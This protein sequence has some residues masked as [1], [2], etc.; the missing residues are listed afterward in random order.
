MIKKL[1]SI[2]LCVVLLVSVLPQVGFAAGTVTILSNRTSTETSF[3]KAPAGQY[4]Q[5]NYGVQLNGESADA[6][7]FN[8][9]V[10]PEG[11]GVSV[12][13]GG[14][15]IVSGNTSLKSFNLTATLKT[16]STATATVNIPIESSVLYD[17]D[18]NIYGSLTATEDSDGNKYLAAN[19]EASDKWTQIKPGSFGGVGYGTET[20]KFKFRLSSVTTKY[21]FVD[22]WGTYLYA[23]AS[24]SDPSKFLL[25]LKSGSHDKYI[26]SGD[27]LLSLNQWHEVKFEFDFGSG[28][29]N[30]YVDDRLDANA[31]NVTMPEATKT[32]GTLRMKFN[33]DDVVAYSGFDYTPELNISENSK[34]LLVPTVNNR[35][36]SVKF[37]ATSDDTS[38][39]ITWSLAENY[40]GVT[41]N[42]QT[43]LVTVGN[44]ASSGDITVKASQGTQEKTATLSLTKFYEDF[45]SFSSGDTPSSPWI[46]GSFI[47]D[48][49]NTYLSSTKDI[50][51]RFFFPQVTSGNNLVLEADVG[52]LS[53]TITL[54]A[55]NSWTTLATPTSFEIFNRSQWNKVK[56]VLDYKNST[57]SVFVNGKAVSYQK[58]MSNMADIKAFG[59]ESANV[60]NVTVYNVSN[61]A[62][63]AL[64]VELPDVVAGD[65]TNLS[66]KYFDE[67]G[68][69]ENCTD[70]KWYISDVKDSGYTL[71]DGENTKTLL[72]TN[73]MIGK[74]LKAVVTPAH[75]D[76]FDLS[77]TKT[78]A[79]KEAICRV[80][81]MS[82]E[83]T[84]VTVGGEAADFTKTN[85]I[86]N[87]TNVEVTL[88]LKTAL[89]IKK[90]FVVALAY[91]K[92]NEL[93]ELDCREIEL[94]E[95]TSSLTQT[96]NLTSG[97]GIYKIFAWD[98]NANT[99]LIKV[100][101]FN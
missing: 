90:T 81:D 83:V 7:L 66:Y 22:N 36:A 86:N 64:N 62:P 19:S 80:L 41:I 78:G 70:I 3:I 55:L 96:L 27:N 87:N 73:Q 44:T 92:D 11:Q 57:Y 98:E 54:Y 46:N 26:A 31:K 95:N 91:Y 75:I 74:Y 82:A 47:T 43:G 15:V 39:P 49:D 99:P 35:T 8:W 10:S 18:N 38:T 67:S 34:S 50:T 33:I 69:A 89:Q 28:K 5:M 60:D 68:M 1:T 32:Q 79:P 21:L 93:S 40:T 53:G 29:F 45:E 51:T 59:F 84:S 61:T 16:D 25:N 88:N 63:E 14:Q 20:L 101:S 12:K 52:Y 37:E 17:F 13:E 30:V 72:T 76:E 58:A 97:A 85:V 94:D 6:N 65:N 42:S 9:T 23:V 56:I 4:S 71:I 48:E 24:T 100:I 2:L 77:V